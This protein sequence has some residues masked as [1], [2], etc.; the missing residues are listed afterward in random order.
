[1][2]AALRGGNIDAYESSSAVQLIEAF[3]RSVQEDSAF[4]ERGYLV[5]S[6]EFDGMDYDQ[7][8]EA[9]A[10]RFEREG[11]GLRRVNWRLR[12]WGVS[13]QRYWGCPIPVIY[14]SKCD[15]VPV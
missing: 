1:M 14:C 4:T 12:D 11:T 10:A 15:A 3:E 7:A 5:N 2:R 13:R 8:F 6:G 9:M